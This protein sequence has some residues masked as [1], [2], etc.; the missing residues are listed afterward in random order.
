MIAVL[1]VTILYLCQVLN[2]ANLQDSS[3]SKLSCKL[4][5]NHSLAI[6]SYLQMLS[7][8]VAVNN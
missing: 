1:I 5:L 3:K 7:V 4:S 8:I 6:F 2:A